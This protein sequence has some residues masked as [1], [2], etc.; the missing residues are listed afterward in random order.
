MRNPQERDRPVAAGRFQCAGQSFLKGCRRLG[1]RAWR[2]ANKSKVRVRR[3]E[4][5]SLA[6]RLE[7]EKKDL[8]ALVGEMETEFLATGDGLSHLARRLA[9]IQ[10]ECRS[11]S[12]LAMG[13]TQDA[14]VQFAFQLLKKAEDLVLA[15]YDQ[16]DHLFATFGELQQRIALLSKQ[17]EE[18]MRVLLPLNFITMSLRIEASRQPAE[19]QAVFVSLAID[20]N[21]TVNE[22]RATLEQQI[23]GFHAGEL[24]IQALVQEISASIQRHR[25][26]VTTAL[27]TSRNHLRAFGD[28]L[29]NAGAGATELS[30]LNHAVTKHIGGIVMAQQCQ[31]IT[32]KKIEHVG[33][34]M[35]EIR[36]QLDDSRPEAMESGLG[37]RQFVLHAGQIQLEQVQGVFD[38]LNRAADSVKAGIQG[39]RSDSGTASDAAVKVGSTALDETVANLCQN[40]I[41]GI[42]A[43]IDQAVLRI[44]EILAA[45]EPLQAAFI[46]CTTKATSLAGDVRLAALNAQVFA[47]HAAD[48][49]T[50]EVL[51]GRVRAV[52]DDAIPRVGQMG[53]ELYQTAQM[54][55][56]LG[57]QLADFQALGKV[58][59][60]ILT[61]ESVL[62]KEK[63][64]QLEGAIPLMVE[65]ISCQQVAFAQ[66]V[67]AVLA[68][69]QFPT[70]VAETRSRSL[71]FFEYLVTW[72][73]ADGAGLA[74]DAAASGNIDRL[75]ANYTMES[76]RQAH[77]AVLLTGLPLVRA[78]TGLPSSNLLNDVPSAPAA[79]SG[80]EVFSA[81]ES[82]PEQPMSEILSAST[83]IP[84]TPQPTSVAEEPAEEVALGANVELF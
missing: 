75:R 64:A 81:G 13:Q 14:A 1:Q 25:L 4:A 30:Q 43:I 47:I 3:V 54:V 57:Q 19:A 78:A 67:D 23:A 50:L 73:G 16:Y 51:A 32:R 2:I 24:I 49:A 33:E 79:D 71:E 66:S 65:R 69:V 76:E 62:S 36:N 15:S 41:S 5:S 83:T 40:G 60:D 80:A 55:N 21:R 9:N 77:A 8:F 74:M 61:D 34:A 26:E 56:N 7:E 20:L 53:A 72:G 11:L 63:L 10:Q 29:C 6:R 59:R 38:E 35:D 44:A 45:F 58:E 70:T 27:V 39:L 82:M 18:I 48:G 84:S 31:D 46:N 37:T 12:D 68:K 22:V 52:S 42:L 28:A 17:H